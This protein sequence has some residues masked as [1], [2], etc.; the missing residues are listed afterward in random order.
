MK[1]KLERLFEKREKIA[2]QILKEINKNKRNNKTI[3]KYIYI[4]NTIFGSDNHIPH[5]D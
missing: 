3:T 1:T 5:I 4:D 2:K